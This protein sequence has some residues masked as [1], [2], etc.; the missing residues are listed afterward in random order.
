VADHLK[1][2]VAAAEEGTHD[3]RFHQGR[4]VRL[5]FRNGDAADELTHNLCGG[6]VDGNG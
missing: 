6:R 2:G 1:R 3:D 5:S 4:G